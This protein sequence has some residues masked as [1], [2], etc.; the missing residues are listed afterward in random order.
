[1]CGVNTARSL[2]PCSTPLTSPEATRSFRIA[3]GQGKVREHGGKALFKPTQPTHVTSASVF[4]TNYNP[5][6]ASTH[7]TTHPLHT[8]LHSHHT[9]T[10]FP[11][12]TPHRKPP[13]TV[14]Q[15][16][17][18]PLHTPHYTPTTFPCTPKYTV[19]LRPALTEEEPLLKISPLNDTC[20]S[21][22]VCGSVEVAPDPRAVA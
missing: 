14:P 8:P 9:P 10:T 13:H 11:P 17:T 20:H 19:T 4:P 21:N 18:H 7:R 16:T 1:M 6:Q 15:P 12:H 5:P 3:E 22:R 2:R